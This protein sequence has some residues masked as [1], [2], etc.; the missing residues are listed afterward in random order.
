MPML[1]VVD[2]DYKATSRQILVSCLA[3]VPLGTMPTFIH[4]AGMLYLIG[5]FIMGLIFLAYG[6]VL[7]VKRTRGRT[8]A[9]SSSAR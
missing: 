1:P 4:M 5:A 8:P 9:N 3:L 2:D 7:V 6:A